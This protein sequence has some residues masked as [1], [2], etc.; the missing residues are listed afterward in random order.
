MTDADQIWKIEESLWT[1]GKEGFRS[2]MAEDA[3]MIFPPP[4]GILQG[5]KIIDGLEEAPRWR[6][7]EMTERSITRQ[8]DFI[9]IAYRASAERDG[10]PIYEAYCSSTYIA[11]G[12]GWQILHHQQTPIAS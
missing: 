12:T 3:V 5:P 2:A 4:S 9:L 10:L 8:G 11:T 7:V 6:T 1:S